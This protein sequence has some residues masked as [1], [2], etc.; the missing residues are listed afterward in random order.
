MFSS[1]LTERSGRPVSSSLDFNITLAFVICLRTDI[2][3]RAVMW[4]ALLYAMNMHSDINNKGK[5]KVGSGRS[6]M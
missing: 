2:H 4:D 1:G 6:K 3:Y 5:K